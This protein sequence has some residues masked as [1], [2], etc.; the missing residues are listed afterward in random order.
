MLAGELG[1]QRADGLHDDNLEL[2]RDLRHKA[3]D[4]LHEAVNTAFVAS[5]EKGGD[6]QRGDAAV[7]I[8]Y[9]ILKVKVASSHCSRMLDG[10]LCR[11]MRKNIKQDNSTV[12]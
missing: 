1:T 5:L 10:H 8:C 9:E 12:V 3:G 4:L 2:I 6:G 11:Q 7:H